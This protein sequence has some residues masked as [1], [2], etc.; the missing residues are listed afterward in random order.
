MYMY[1][2]VSLRACADFD[3]GCIHFIIWDVQCEN[4]TTCYDI[5]VTTSGRSV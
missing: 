1:S 2:M 4:F 5:P 3:V